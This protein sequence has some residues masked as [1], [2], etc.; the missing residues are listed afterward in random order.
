MVMLSWNESVSYPGLPLQV[1]RS[2]LVPDLVLF[3]ECPDEQLEGPR[4]STLDLLWH[5]APPS[6][7]MCVYLKR[8]FI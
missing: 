4:P 5:F 2:W 8:G 7:G 6:P 3:S 1:S